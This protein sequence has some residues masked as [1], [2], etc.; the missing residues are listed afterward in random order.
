MAAAGF[1]GVHRG[2]S[3]LKIAVLDDEKVFCDAI[4]RKLH[5][6]YKKMQVVASVDEYH[7]GR[8]LLYEVDDGAY[9]DIYLLD[10]NLPDMSGME[11]A[12]KLREIAP[13]SYII[14]L[15]AYPQF[16]IEGYDARA[17]QYLLK[18]EWE[19]KLAVSLD[20]IQK[21]MSEDTGPSYCIAVG[22]QYRK[23]PVRWI[24]HIFIR[25]ER[26]LFL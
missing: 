11:L 24:Y 1:S 15:T 21:E 25:T 6:I 3:M 18:D 5:S 7:F 2:R 8:E 26:I 9:Y 20:K 13:Y 16:A 10:I 4:K 19:H 12:R 23:I 22:S 14:F 17:Y